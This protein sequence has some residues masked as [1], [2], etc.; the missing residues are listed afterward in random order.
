MPRSPMGASPGFVW[1]THEGHHDN[2]FAEEHPRA[3]FT[4]LRQVGVELP[5]ALAQE[6]QSAS[7][8]LNTQSLVLSA[9]SPPLLSKIS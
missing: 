7:V 9:V 8:P 5:G 3:G 2:E 4:W 6:A 1:A